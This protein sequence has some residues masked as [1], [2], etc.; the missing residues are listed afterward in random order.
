[1]KHVSEMKLTAVFR[2]E[3]NFSGKKN[4][5]HPLYGNEHFKKKD[6]LTQVT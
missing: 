3:H 6:K 4:Y 1:M 5:H 2:C